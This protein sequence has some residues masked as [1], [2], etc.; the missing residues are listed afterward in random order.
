MRIQRFTLV[1]ALLLLAAA[2]YAVFYFKL[3]QASA[4][5][6]KTVTLLLK[7]KNVR[8][9]F[10]QT[11]SAGAEAAAKEAG[12]VLEIHGPLQ[13]TDA[14]SQAELLDEAIDRKPQAI[15][16]AP[17]DDE[18]IVRE[19][20]RAQAAGIKL[21]VI[22]TPSK[23]KP[24]PVSVANNHLEAGRQ[25]GMAVVRATRD[26]PYLAIVSDFKDSGVSAEREKGILEAISP[27]PASY[28]GTYYGEDSEDKA[29]EIVKQALARKP[30]LNAVVAL[31][32]AAALGAA[33]ALKE[34]EVTDRV[35]LIGFDSSIYQ[36]KLLED[37]SLKA[38]VVQKPFNMGYL[39]VKAALQLIDGKKTAKTT[40]IDS[41]IVTRDNMYSPENQKL[42]FPFNEK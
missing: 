18:R 32:E 16:V 31:N 40:Y 8:S 42:L 23:L 1:L 24:A 28:V 12:A 10:W 29:Y 19:L 17:I 41:L 36:I 7:S 13:E 15:V 27:Y 5:Q 14:D 20:Q 30:G 33:K 37:G 4:G 6:E 26:K 38:I 11:V 21:V 34:K 2:V 35:T 39:G 9:D 25:A 22:D 3:Y